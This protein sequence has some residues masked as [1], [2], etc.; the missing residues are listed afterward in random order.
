MTDKKKQARAQDPFDAAVTLLLKL[1]GGYVNDP[2]DSGGETKYGI[3]KQSY[4]SLSIADLT[5]EDVIRIYREDW[6]QRY[7]YDALP[8]P[9][10]QLMLL[11]AVNMGPVPA[12]S[13]LQRAL[14]DLG[15]PVTSDG[16]I[17]PVTRRA[18]QRAAEEQKADVV[19]G[20]VIASAIERYRR[21]GKPRFLAGWVRRALA[22][23]EGRI[24]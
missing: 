11:M 12:H 13:F 4:P 7:G 5:E 3:S 23:V 20:L 8:S 18:A 22:T 17:G 6:W 24:G 10:G 19:V 14:A 1:E 16:L 15:Y 9:L 21:L 2:E